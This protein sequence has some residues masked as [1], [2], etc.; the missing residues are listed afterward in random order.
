MCWVYFF[1]NFYLLE[2]E[3]LYVLSDYGYIERSGNVNE[4]GPLATHSSIYCT[5]LKFTIRIRYYKC[6]H[7]VDIVIYAR[8]GFILDYC[9]SSTY[10]QCILVIIQPFGLF[11]H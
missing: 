2:N 10:P 11:S 3:T 4:T 1:Y 6:S 9:F 8:H 5:P 7:L